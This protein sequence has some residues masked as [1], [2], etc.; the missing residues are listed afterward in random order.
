[1]ALIDRPFLITDEGP[2]D[3]DTDLPDPYSESAL[4]A[5]LGLLMFLLSCLLG[6]LAGYLIYGRAA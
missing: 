2:E 6:F 3:V 1:M 5:G 4:L